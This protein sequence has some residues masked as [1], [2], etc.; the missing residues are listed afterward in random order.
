LT[1]IRQSSHKKN[2]QLFFSKKH[3]TRTFGSRS[4]SQQT[5]GK[6]QAKNKMSFS[7]SS[8]VETKWTKSEKRFGGSKRSR[9]ISE[10]DFYQN[11]SFT[12]RVRMGSLAQAD[13]NEH[14]SLEFDPPVEAVVTFQKSRKQD[15]PKREDGLES[16]ESH[17]VW[18]DFSITLQ[19]R[20]WNWSTERWNQDRC[21]YAENNGHG[22]KTLLQLLE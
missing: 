8:S 13:W 14:F 10:A 7:S 2:Q 11:S 1:I 15:V 9:K 3:K 17:Q 4:I 22:L 18:I 6:A 5:K 12:T 20:T 19:G 16:K 21:Y